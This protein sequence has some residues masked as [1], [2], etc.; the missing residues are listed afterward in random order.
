LDDIVED[1]EQVKFINETIHTIEFGAKV[2]QAYAKCQNLAS[3][4][5]F[6]NN[7]RK[8]ALEVIKPILDKGNLKQQVENGAVKDALKE[9]FYRNKDR[10]VE[11]SHCLDDVLPGPPTAFSLSISPSGM[12]GL[13]GSVEI[14]IA[15]DLGFGEYPGDFIVFAGGCATTGIGGEADVA[16]V[17]GVWT[18]LDKI[19]GWSFTA[20][21]SFEFEAGIGIDIVSNH[22]GVIGGTIGIG[23]GAGLDVNGGACCDFCGYFGSHQNFCGGNTLASYDQCD[24][25]KLIQSNPIFGGPFIG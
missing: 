22:E 10:I 2:A 9:L 13:G 25:G 1:L 12:L 6:L 4:S 20:G 7:M 16:V 14:G 5:T 17:I 8:D 21:G 18:G 3:A 15:A 11:F 19:P 24:V 23:A